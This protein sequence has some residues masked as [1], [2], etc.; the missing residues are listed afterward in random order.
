M[1]VVEKEIMKELMITKED[2][3]SY[4][5]K[6]KTITKEEYRKYLKRKFDT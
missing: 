3:E 4:F 1:N 2:Y 6:R 5:N